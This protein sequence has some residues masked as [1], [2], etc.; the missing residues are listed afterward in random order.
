MKMNTLT[1]PMVLKMLLWIVIFL[2]CNALVQ[3][4][5]F[6]LCFWGQILITKTKNMLLIIN[7]CQ[8]QGDKGCEKTKKKILLGEAFDTIKLHFS[9]HKEAYFVLQHCKVWPKFFLTKLTRRCGPVG[10]RPS[11]VNEL[12]TKLFIEQPRLHRIC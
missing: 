10:N 4:C 11:P 5:M 6:W 2:Q 3:Q 9:F 12:V 8:I 1:K 7:N